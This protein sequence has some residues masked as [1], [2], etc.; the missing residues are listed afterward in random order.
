MRTIADAVERIERTLG[1]ENRADAGW[2]ESKHKR[3]ANGQF[4][5]GGGSSKKSASGEAASKTSGGSSDAEKS[6][7][8]VRDRINDLGAKNIAIYNE[9]YKDRSMSDLSK[10]PYAFRDDPEVSKNSKEIKELYATQDRLEDEIAQQSGKKPVGGSGGNPG[11]YAPKNSGE[12]GKPGGSVISLN[13][14]HD[15]ATGYYGKELSREQ[16][17]S[18]LKKH[19]VGRMSTQRVLNAFDRLH[20]TYKP[21]V[22]YAKKGYLP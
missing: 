11:I 4:G 15:W 10:D 9:K 7:K 5:S 21:A 22:P 3:A 17:V 19:G 14:A 13:H 16:V 1:R 2:D 8:A 18:E 20:G 6:L 12:Y